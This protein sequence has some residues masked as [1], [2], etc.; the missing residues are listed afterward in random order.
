LEGEMSRFNVPKPYG[1]IYKIENKINGRIY[2]GQT[3]QDLNKRIFEHVNNNGKMY[4][5]N[6]IRKH[7]I[8]SFVFLEIDRAYSRNELNEKEKY[9]I[10]KL[11]CKY[12]NGYNLTN[13]GEGGATWTGGHHTEEAKEKLRIA[14]TGRK[15][16]EEEK[17]KRAI[18][19]SGKKRS[20]T[21]KHKQSLAAKGKPK[22][23]ESIAKRSKTR[24]DKTGPNKIVSCKGCNKIM[25]LRPNDNRKY[26]NW[27][28]RVLHQINPMK[29][30]KTTRFIRKK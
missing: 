18:S 29:G 13:G 24:F 9:W 7:N 2:I 4:I 23:K 21:T 16:S 1:I 14:N 15:Q 20:K 11:N 6:A 19:N 22:S 27:E 28:C 17:K 5:Q 25:E 26:C 8:K 10:K 30:K 12:P 3:K